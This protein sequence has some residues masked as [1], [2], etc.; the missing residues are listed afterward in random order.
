MDPVALVDGLRSDGVDADHIPEVADIVRTVAS[1]ARTGDVLLVMSNG[2]F[3]GIHER[4]LE[5]LT[6]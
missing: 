3:G 1:D 5:A 6:P 4:L 2:S